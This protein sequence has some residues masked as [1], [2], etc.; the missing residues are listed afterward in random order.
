MNENRTSVI[1][2]T[3]ARVAVLIAGLFLVVAVGAPFLLYD[4][5][6][7]PEAVFATR[8]CCGTAPGSVAPPAVPALA[9]SR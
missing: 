5:P 2:R 9:P 7:S 6:P 8:L 3:T 4:A 1:S